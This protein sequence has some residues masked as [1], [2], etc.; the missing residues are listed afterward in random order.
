MVERT[1]RF[2]FLLKENQAKLSHSR[3]SLYGQTNLNHAESVLITEKGGE[4]FKFWKC[5]RT[6]LI[7]T[8]DLFIRSWLR[9]QMCLK[10]TSHCLLFNS[11]QVVHPNN[12]KKTLKNLRMILY[13]LCW[14]SYFFCRKTTISTIGLWSIKGNQTFVLVQLCFMK[15][16]K[17]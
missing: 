9:K 16:F 3:I 5:F 11:K 2:L 12:L 8:S 17:I 4:K 1:T 13:L 14:P 15:V 10:R 6:L 7:V